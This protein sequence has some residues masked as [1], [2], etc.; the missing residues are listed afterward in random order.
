[1]KIIENVFNICLGFIV[2][3]KKSKI[4][5]LIQTNFK[6]CVLFLKKILNLFVL[7]KYFISAIFEAHKK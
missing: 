7:Y 6:Y 5:N 3:Q 4:Y 1:M 2:A